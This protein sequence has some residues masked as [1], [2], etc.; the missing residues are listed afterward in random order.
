MAFQQLLF[1]PVSLLDLNSNVDFLG[2]VL[3]F[4][5]LALLESPICFSWRST[6]MQLYPSSDSLL[7]HDL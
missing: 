5:L 2:K 6:H 3:A 7:E 4:S 1:I